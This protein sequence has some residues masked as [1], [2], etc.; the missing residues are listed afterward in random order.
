MVGS[1]ELIPG[2]VAL[3]V[4]VPVVVVL[5]RHVV[6]PLHNI[7]HI[8]LTIGNLTLLFLNRG[9]GTL[10]LLLVLIPVLLQKISM[11][12]RCKRVSRT[13]EFG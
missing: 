11:A 2:Y 9:N 3:V 10:L 4:V 5:D 7:G 6:V 8:I 13:P 12:L 1:P